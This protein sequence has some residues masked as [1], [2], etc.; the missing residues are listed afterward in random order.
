MGIRKKDRLAIRQEVLSFIR[1]F[2]NNGE[3]QEVIDCFTGGCCYYFANAIWLR[4]GNFIFDKD[5]KVEIMY[6]E[7]K[8]HFGCK[9]DDR[10]Y[11][12]TGDV[13]EKYK[14]RSWFDASRDDPLLTERINRD[15]I[16]F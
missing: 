14:W 4:F 11:D 7:V 15:C 13:T 5:H 10:V 16:N 9:V 2:T 1:R 12:V 6:D 8:N 3:R